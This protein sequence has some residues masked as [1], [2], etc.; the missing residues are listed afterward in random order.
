MKVVCSR[1]MRTMQRAQTLDCLYIVKERFVGGILEG[2]REGDIMVRSIR[3]SCD[4]DSCRNTGSVQVWL[5]FYGLVTTT[6]VRYNRHR[7]SSFPT[8]FY[9]SCQHAP[10]DEGRRLATGISDY[11][12][13]KLTDIKCA[14]WWFCH[15]MIYRHNYRIQSGEFT[16][17]GISTSV[18]MPQ[19]TSK[20]AMFD[21]N[22]KTNTWSAQLCTFSDF[23]IANNVNYGIQ[24]TQVSGV[25]T[26]LQNRTQDNSQL[27]FPPPVC[28][29]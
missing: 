15:S 29:N 12:S 2:W 7:T 3:C 21:D 25:R 14:L 20:L 26:K 23:F 22:T 28:S 9:S 19:T 10:F 11:C 24:W 13:S 18:I 27:A 4:P 6:C 5:T 8:I 17:N 16:M 1:K